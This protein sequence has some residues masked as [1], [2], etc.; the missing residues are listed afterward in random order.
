[1]SP[2]LHSTAENPMLSPL[3]IVPLVERASLIEAMTFSGFFIFLTTITAWSDETV[4]S[5]NTTSLLGFW[6][7]VFCPICNG[8]YS[9]AAVRDTE[10]RN[11]TTGLPEAEVFGFD[12]AACCLTLWP[13]AAERLSVIPGTT[14]PR[15]PW[16]P[17]E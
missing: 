9:P 3:I 13:P 10:Y 7:M 11:P 5:G 4:P 2:F 12:G 1:M 14:V 17:L 15:A 16:A 6:P 8:Q